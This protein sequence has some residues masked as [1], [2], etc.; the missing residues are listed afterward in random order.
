MHAPPLI[1][2]LS[3]KIQNIEKLIFNN[4]MKELEAPP[5]KEP[6]EIVTEKTITGN[7]NNENFESETIVGHFF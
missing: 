7:A 5:I 3:F 4:G 2:I 1:P 6:E